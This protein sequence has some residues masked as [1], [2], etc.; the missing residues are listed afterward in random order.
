[1]IV[2]VSGTN[3]FLLQD[4][5]IRRTAPF[6]EKYGDLALERIDGE[7]ADYQ[8]IQEAI[9][10]LPFLVDHKM[11]L[12]RRPSANKSFVVAVEKILQQVPD[13]TELIIIEP[14]LDKRSSYYK[15][16]KKSTE[17][18]EY[19]ELDQNQL[20]HWLTD[21][22]AQNGGSISMGDARYL[23]ERIGMTQ[24][25]LAS[26]IDKLLLNN[27]K[28]TRQTVDLLTEATPQST[29]FQLLEAAF[30]N[31][32]ARVAALYREQRALKVEPPQIVAMIVWQLH[33]I[34]LIKTAGT[35]SVDQISKE[36]HLNSYVVSKSVAIAR[37]LTFEQLKQLISEL[38]SIDLRSK[39]EAID[40]DE[41]LQ[42][43]LLRIATKA[44]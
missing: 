1:M 16:L 3:S 2:T 20:A 23:I 35:R 21:R 42:L 18:H 29:I 36:A 24:Q 15:F 12:L 14:K 26:E 32:P 38:L 9:T 13:T 40:S 22:A 31:N 8:R 33:I 39:R 10:S 17:F 7:E 27:G 25:S 30:S 37:K 6:L 11:V 41:A 43:Y 28:V 44:V 34:A 5:L 4:E 19:S